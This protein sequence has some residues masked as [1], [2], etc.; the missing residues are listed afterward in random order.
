MNQFIKIWS[1]LSFIFCAFGLQAQDMGN[2]KVMHTLAGKN[3]FTHHGFFVA[4]VVNVSSYDGQTA[5]MP[6]LRAAWTINRSVSIGLAGYGLAPTISRS[7]IVSEF[8]VRPLAGYGGLFIE[9]IVASNQLIHVTFPVTLGA[10]WTGYVRDWA[11]DNDFTFRNERSLIDDHIFWYVEP[12]V[13][14]ELNVASFFRLA[15]GAGYRYTSDIELIK[16]PEDA[17]RGM[18]YALELKFGIF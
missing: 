17:L 16:T 6:G 11:D 9:P 13:R 3:A 7:D 18:S 4:P 2:Q 15:L 5:I 10:G 1:L 12:G 14:A 8:D